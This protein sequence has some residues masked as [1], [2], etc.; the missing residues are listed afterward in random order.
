[1]GE[2]THFY[3]TQSTSLTTRDEHVEK[4]SLETVSVL[5]HC[6]LHVSMRLVGKEEIPLSR[7][8]A[9]LDIQTVEMFLWALPS[10]MVGTSLIAVIDPTTKR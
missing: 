10:D 3:R 2:N 9:R 7:L 5:C 4:S 1:M 8:Y 6:L